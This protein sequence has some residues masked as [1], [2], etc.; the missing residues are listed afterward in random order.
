MTTSHVYVL[1]ASIIGGNEMRHV[2]HL[3]DDAETVTEN[4]TEFCNLANRPL[5]SS[6]HL[7][8]LGAGPNHPGF[9]Q[10]LTD[11]NLTHNP[12]CP[13]AIVRRAIEMLIAADMVPQ[14]AETDHALLSALYASFATENDWEHFTRSSQLTALNY[15]IFMGVIGD[16]PDDHDPRERMLVTQVSAA[17]CVAMVNARA[18]YQ[19]QLTGNGSAD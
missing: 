15:L 1:H 9:Q 13:T 3:C 5:L 12:G 16:E 8:A 2:V 11:L 18:E 6:A 4:L 10:A 14:T 17:L 7:L 19:R